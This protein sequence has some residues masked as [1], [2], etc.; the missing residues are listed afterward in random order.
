MAAL[1]D[2]GRD[3][4]TGRWTAIADENVMSHTKIVLTFAGGNP[5]SYKGFDKGNVDVREEIEG[6]DPLSVY[7]FDDMGNIVLRNHELMLDM[8]VNM[9]MF[10]RPGMMDGDMM[11]GDMMDGDMMDGDM[12]AML[13]CNGEMVGEDGID[14]MSGEFR[15][16]NNTGSDVEDRDP[17]DA[18]DPRGG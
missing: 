16:F 8:N 15:I 5:L 2:Q 6:L 17:T 14:A 3:L 7:V 12:M 10:M 18:A 11:D 13:S 4:L 9:C 1:N